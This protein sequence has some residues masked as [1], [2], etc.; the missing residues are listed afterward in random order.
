MVLEPK[1]AVVIPVY[2]HSVLV[3]EAI[4]SALAQQAE[5]PIVV[6]IVNDGCQYPETDRVSRDFALAHPERVIYLYRPNGGLSA[7]RNT[8]IEFA[9]NTWNSLAAVYL[10]DADNRI[11]PQTIAKFYQ[12]LMT[13]DRIGWVYPTINMFGKEQNSAYDYRGKYSVLRHLRFNICEAGSLIRREVFD[14]GCRYDESMKL[15]FEDW[16]FWWQAIACGYIG[17]HLP[18][19]GFQYRKRFASMLSNSE[20]DGAEI[21]NYMK[22]KHRKLFS[23]SNIIHWEHKEAPRYAIFLADTKQ[24][25]LTSDPTQTD[26]L[27]SQSEFIDCYHRGGIMPVRYHR[28][29]FLVFTNSKVLS[30]LQQQKLIHGIF[31]L[32]EQ[33]QNEANFAFL[34]IDDSESTALTLDKRNTT[35]N[36]D[37]G[38]SEHLIMT[39]IQVMDNCLLDPQEEWIHSLISPNPKPKVIQLQLTIPQSTVAEAP[40]AGCAYDLLSSYRSLRRSLSQSEQPIWD[41]HINYLP[42]RTLMYEDARLALDCYPVYPRIVKSDS[43]PQ[44]GFILSILEFGGVEKVALN[45]AKVFHEAG[46]AVHLFI[47]GS[48]MQQLPEWAQIFATVNFYH[49]PSMSPWQGEQYWGTKSDAWSQSSEQMTAKGLLSWLDVAIN[50]HNA[51]VN[52]I[53]GQLRRSG[54]IT[55]MS[56]HVHDL[57][58]WQRPAGYTY[59]SLGYEHAYDL[60]IPCSHNLAD[61]CH[62]MGIPEDKIVVLPN[63][64]G[65]P[66]DSDTRKQIVTRRSQR[67]SHDSLKVLFLG[68]FDRQK[69]LDRLVGVVN[70]SRQLK[71]PIE[72]KLVGKNILGSE[73]TST[74][75]MSLADLIEPPAM[76][77]TELN[78]LY[79]WAD[80]LFLPSYWEGLPL[81]ILEAMRLGVVV[82]ASDVGAVTEAVEHEQT[83]LVIPNMPQEMYVNLAIAL[84]QQLLTNP[85]ELKRMSQAAAAKTAELSW[86]HTSVELLAKLEQL[87][88]QTKADL[89]MN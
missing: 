60:I 39:N 18:E 5:F 31:W 54:V 16:E 13:D 70:R 66:L 17:Q 51:T 46:W 47:F 6:I 50:F 28:P 36:L 76:T 12:A 71:L 1:V 35:S 48:R 65:Y 82:C 55:A 49:E 68:R 45:L 44:V 85:V 3:A 9:L 38:E 7:A 80:V 83:G 22:R 67:N 15:G 86:N 59:L 42:A 56:L 57:S 11:A 4:S 78:E 8:G 32:L 53:M 77:P 89:L 14:G 19:S 37:V 20:L 21:K 10:L 74:E 58:P 73:N 52:N 43:C 33:S 34:H 64:G 27:V 69:G 41:W 87:S 2:K 23:H 63:A 88:S 24:I 26:C 79:G 75:L 81:T 29:Y 62:A 84:L 25:A 40:I 30:F 72:W 61:C